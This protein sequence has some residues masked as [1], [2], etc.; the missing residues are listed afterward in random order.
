[1]AAPRVGPAAVVISTVAGGVGGPARATRVAL[2]LPCGVVFG[3]GHLYIAD[4]GSVRRVDPHTDRLT[5]PAGT[6][7]GAPLRDRRPA[8]T[9]SLST[10]TCGVT[11][12]HSGNL[13]IADDGLHNRVRVVAAST[14]T[15]YGKAMTA[16]D[17]YTV[18]GD[19]TR[20]FSGDGGPATSVG[21]NAR[22]AAVD[23]AG[24]LLIADDGSSPLLDSNTAQFG[25]ESSIG[26][27]AWRC[28]SSRRPM[29]GMIGWRGGQSGAVV[30]GP[31]RARPRVHVTA[32]SL[33]RRR[34]SRRPVAT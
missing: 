11:V 29:P 18:A 34:L 16:G 17:I 7:A 12:D 33:A 28:G 30:S 23:A 5:T 27:D 1:V 10:P 14:G 26:S 31:M 8:T 13:V 24:N 25:T 20:G 3:A 15:F 9:A 4:A 6:G 32:G 2:S 22:G 19:G 21:L